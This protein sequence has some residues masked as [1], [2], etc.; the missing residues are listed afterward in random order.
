MTDITLIS[1]NPEPERKARRVTRLPPSSHFT[2]QQA[3]DYTQQA[4]NSGNI[5]DIMIVGW[6]KDGEIYSISS[7]MSREWALWLL[8]ELQDYVRQVGRYTE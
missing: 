5:K 8:H 2:V 3:L 1:E 7:H 4:V 6:R